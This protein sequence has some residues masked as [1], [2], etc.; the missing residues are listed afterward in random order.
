[1]RKPFSKQEKQ[2]LIDV[3]NSGKSIRKTSPAIAKS[4]GRSTMSV[5]SK[6]YVIRKDLGLA[7]ERK[8]R[9]VK[10]RREAE[11]STQTATANDFSFNFKPSRTEIHRDHVRLYF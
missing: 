10:A 2:I 1:M 6:M 3:V 7:P 4:M 5:A 9:I 11:V 8:K